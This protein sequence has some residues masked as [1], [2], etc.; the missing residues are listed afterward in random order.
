MGV[1]GTYDVT[2]KTPMG[3]QKGTL[4]VVPSGESFTGKL[5]SPMGAAEIA[6]GKVSGDSL[7]WKMGI[8]VPMAMSL[9]CEA[10][11]TGN[12][13]A[14]S[15]KAGVFGSMALTGVRKG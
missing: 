4:T 9:D 5:E 2:V 1:A 6:D 14:G 11:V 15:V 13:L 7:S 3:D 8:S 12:S 10:T